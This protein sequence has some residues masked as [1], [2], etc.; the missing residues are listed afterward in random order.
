MPP[1]T[2]PSGANNSSDDWGSSEEQPSAPLTYGPAYLGDRYFYRVVACSLASIAGV[3]LLGSIGLA[4]YDK[5][6]PEFV[7]AIGSTAVG[8]LASVLMINRR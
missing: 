4:A 2:I 7:V 3:S 5:E 6:I 8:A 1:D